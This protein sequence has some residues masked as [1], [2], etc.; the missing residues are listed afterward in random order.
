M[1]SINCDLLPPYLK[2]LKM[3][4]FDRKDNDNNNDGGGEMSRS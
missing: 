2:D 1:A 3:E 4:D